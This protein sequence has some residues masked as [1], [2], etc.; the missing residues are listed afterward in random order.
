MKTSVIITTF[1]RPESLVGA[2]NSVLDQNSLPLEIIIV[3]DGFENEVI[4]DLKKTPLV[5]VYT[6]KVSS[7]ANYSRNKGAKLAKGDVLMFLDDDDTWERNK[8]KDQI[9]IFQNDINIGLVYS[10]KIM[11][12]DTDRSKEIYRVPANKSG[13]LYPEILE[14]NI[15]G[16]T[17]SVAIKREVFF[18]AGGFDEEFPAMQD[19]DLWV[20]VCQQVPVEGDGKFN[21]RYTLNK[22]PKKAQISNSGNN[23]EIASRLFLEKYSPLYMK[24]GVSLRKRKSRLYFYIAKSLRNKDFKK[25]FNF[26]MKSF[27]AFPNLPSLAILLLKDLRKF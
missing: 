4:N 8:I 18:K 10:G 14:R 13:F 17:S 20:R 22:N 23:Q 24:E 26:A 27:W 2:V 12:Y 25:S 9:E 15:I 21:V 11:V 5:A 16:T 7:G 1:N 3:N 6:N 19:Y